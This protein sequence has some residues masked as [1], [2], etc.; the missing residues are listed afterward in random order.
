MMCKKLSVLSQDS[1]PEHHYAWLHMCSGRY[2]IPAISNGADNFPQKR[3]G[4]SSNTTS[5][6]AARQQQ[7]PPQ[8]SSTPMQQYQG[9]QYPGYNV[10]PRLQEQQGQY[11]SQYQGR[12]QPRQAQYQQEGVWEIR[13]T[14]KWLQ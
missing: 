3:I 5:S 9:Q 12:G 10:D 1:V 11:R 13:A 7:P 2:I 14:P 8:Y 4:G 6:V